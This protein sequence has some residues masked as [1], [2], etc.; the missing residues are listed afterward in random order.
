MRQIFLPT[1]MKS[2]IDYPSRYLTVAGAIL[3]FASPAM[4]VLPFSW[5]TDNSATPIITGGSWLGNGTLQPNL[6]PASKSAQIAVQDFSSGSFV[7]DN[8]YPGAGRLSTNPISVTHTI[9]LTGGTADLRLHNS[10]ND[11]GGTNLFNSTGLTDFQGVTEISWTIRYSEPIA[12]RA[13]GFTGSGINLGNRPMGAALFLI[14]P[15]TSQGFDSFTVGMNYTDIFSAPTNTGGFTAGVPVGAVPLV[16]GFNSPS[17]GATSFT[18]DDFV[19]Q[20]RKLLVRG[21][22]Y[23][24]MGGLTSADTELVYIREMTWT[25]SP[26]AGKAFLTDTLFTMS[27]DGD[28][29]SNVGNVPIPEPSGSLLVALGGCLG[30]SY[31]RRSQ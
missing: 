8:I 7:I 18:V 3:L 25:I 19:N 6:D 24:G 26:D 22:D 2:Q 1:A 13:D 31:R 27:M 14:E 21:Y 16:E 4:A 15:G 28:Q 17:A 11:D 10:S 20:N 5:V 12:G 29:H 9:T 30:L 23:D